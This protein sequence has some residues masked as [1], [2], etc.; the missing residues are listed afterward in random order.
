MQMRRFLF[1]CLGAPPGLEAT[2]SK[3]ERRPEQVNQGLQMDIMGQAAKPGSEMDDL[4]KV[5]HQ[6]NQPLTAINNYAQ[7]GCFMIEHGVPDPERLLELFEKIASQSSRTFEISQ[8]LSRV[9]RRLGQ[10]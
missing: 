2:M 10:K 1:V 7:A 5:I 8:E 4:A 9:S 3:E 6:L